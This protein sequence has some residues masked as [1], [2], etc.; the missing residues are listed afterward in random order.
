MATGLLHDERYFWIEL[1]NFLPLGPLA[2]PFPAMDSP[3][4]KRRILN[5]IRA[6]GMMPHL[7]E[8]APREATVD[9]L[10]RV[11]TRDYIALVKRLSEG[12]GAEGREVPDL[13]A[14]SRTPSPSTAPAAI[15]PRRIAGA[16]SRCSR[17]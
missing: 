9:E 14:R 2:Q 13:A 5:L 15:T 16:A 4:G 17:T 3:D 12:Y 8:L 7:V 10:A 1:G 6:S 11:H